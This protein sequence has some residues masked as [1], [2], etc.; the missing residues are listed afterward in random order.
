MRIHNSYIINLQKV[1]RY[2]KSTEDVV[3]TNEQKVPLAKS[4][5]DDFVKWLSL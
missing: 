2:I 1:A 5:K 4:K 3:M